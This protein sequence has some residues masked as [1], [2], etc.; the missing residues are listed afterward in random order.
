MGLVVKLA[1]CL[2]WFYEAFFLL[3]S[4][5]T[6]TAIFFTVGLH[7]ILVLAYLT[8]LPYIFFLGILPART[9]RRAINSGHPN[10]M[11]WWVG[12]TWINFGMHLFVLTYVTWRPRDLP[13]ATFSS[14]YLTVTTVVI[15]ISQAVVLSAHCSLRRALPM[16]AQWEF[17]TQVDE[18]RTSSSSSSRGWSSSRKKKKKKKKEEFWRW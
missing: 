7:P 18:E 8:L 16:Q 14:P 11:L 17:P 4:L 2:A 10:R 15:V 13:L 6:A 1:L 5:V 3:L 9:L 12:A